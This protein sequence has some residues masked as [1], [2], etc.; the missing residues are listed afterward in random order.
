MQGV[1]IANLY[2]WL[3][4]YLHRAHVLMPLHS[5]IQGRMLQVQIQITV[6]ILH[7]VIIFVPRT[8]PYLHEY[9]LIQLDTCQ[10][11]KCKRKLPS[12]ELR[13]G[14]LTAGLVFVPLTQPYLHEYGDDWMSSSPRRLVDKALNSL[15]RK[16]GQQI[17]V[18]SQVLVDESNTGYQSFQNLQVGRENGRNMEIVCACQWVLL[19][20]ARTGRATDSMGCMTVPCQRLL[21]MVYVMH[22]RTATQRYASDKCWHLQVQRVNGVEVLNLKHLKEL[23]EDTSSSS[24]NSSNGNGRLPGG[25]AFVRLELEDDRVIVLNRWDACAWHH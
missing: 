3:N 4:M 5:T 6:L 18:L 17:V 14:H 2:V 1:L 15:M 8:Q 24:S 9:A 7:M 25:E 20:L 16:P 12:F 22:P 19:M 23:L 11:C 21:A 10:S 13:H